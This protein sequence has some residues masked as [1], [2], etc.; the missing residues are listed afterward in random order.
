MN[1]LPGMSLDVGF[2]GGCLGHL[3]LKNTVKEF[4]HPSMRQYGIIHC[5][6]FDELKD[7]LKYI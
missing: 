2:L 1:V 4:N 7:I 6:M 5:V 3:I